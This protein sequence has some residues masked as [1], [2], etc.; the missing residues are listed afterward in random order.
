MIQKKVCM[1]GSFAVGK[2]S[3]VRRFVESIYS[4]KYH[5]TVGVKVD[6][7]V[8]NTPAGE[9]TLLL[10]DIEGAESEHDLR[11][12]Y[13]RG[14][15]GY[16]LV[17]DGTRSD[18]LYKA[19]SLQTRAEEA[20]GTVPFLLLLNK[21][22]LTQSW[23]IQEREMDA[24]RQKSWTVLTTSAKSGQGVEEAFLR[25]AQSMMEDHNG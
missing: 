25:L 16:L 3:L 6:K 23:Q 5:T 11:K 8:V 24:L 15:S 19:L 14:A 2:T 9:A 18:T 22:D 4:D 20:V 21:A 17:A 7:K 12:S 13:L 1:I 10:W